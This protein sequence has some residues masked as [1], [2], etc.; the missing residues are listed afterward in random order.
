[1]VLTDQPGDVRE[2]DRLD[3][4]AL[5]AFLQQND[6]AGADDLLTIKQYPGGA[7]NLTY[8]LVTPDRDMVVRCPPKG[9]KA[10]SAHDMV[11][12]AKIMRGLKPHFET[13]P[14]IYAI[15]EADNVL[16]HPFYVMEHLEGII[17][18]QDI[19]EELS[20]NE[21]DVAQLCGNVLDRF[22]DLHGVDVEAAGLDWMGKGEG[23]TARQISG[24]SKRWR[25]ALT[26]D[27]DPGEDVIAWLE[28][29]TPEGDT[30]ICV[31]HNDYRFDN[32]VLDKDDP[33]KV[34]GVLD[35]EMATLG[36]PL[37]D[38]GATL[39][40]WVEAGDDQVYQMMRRQPTHVPGMLT[41][42]ELVAR[43][44][45]KSGRTIPDF[46]FYEV[47]GL[48]RLAGIIQQIWWRYRAGQTT[49][50]AFKTFGTA[51]NYLISRSRRILEAK[52]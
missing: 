51:A 7:S 33:M 4:D 38:L 20:L 39:A 15:C 3:L 21:G 35:W 24:W 14:E 12:E 48:F 26:D 49:N 44:A 42:D 18:R 19:P 50:P 23:Y 17:L 37:M 45:E 36:D 27:V 41:R 2:D 25:D 22:V 9:R 40:Y 13:V 46:T 34:I 31:I 10:K 1:M 29:N 11:R 52:G 47:Y 16:G 6:L 8:L 28:A 5:K 32:V 43:Y 30:G